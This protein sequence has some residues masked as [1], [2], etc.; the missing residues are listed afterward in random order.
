MTELATALRKSRSGQDGRGGSEADFALL[1]GELSQIRAD[2]TS[3]SDQKRLRTRLRSALA[4][5]P[6]SREQIRARAAAHIEERTALGGRMSSNT[7]GSCGRA[8]IARSSYQ[9]AYES[10][11]AVAR[12]EAARTAKNKPRG[13]AP[14]PVHRRTA[15]FPVSATMCHVT[16]AIAFVSLP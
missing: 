4:R 3:A 15:P 11:F 6:R 13:T 10:S 16:F 7:S 1:E 8:R 12:Q 9:A 2:I 5:D 14:P